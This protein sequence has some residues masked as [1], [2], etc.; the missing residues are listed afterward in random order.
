MRA[1]KILSW[2]I[3]AVI[4]GIRRDFVPIA[5]DER[6]LGYEM[7]GNCS[8]TKHGDCVVS[9]VFLCLQRIMKSAGLHSRA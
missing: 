9:S 4:S 1:L 6:L 2:V 3:V 7:F 8:T 5:Y